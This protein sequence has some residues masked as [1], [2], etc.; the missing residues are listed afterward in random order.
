MS[1][2]SEIFDTLV[3]RTSTIL[4][5]YRH[6]S[7]GLEI[8]KNTNTALVKG[9]SV[10]IGEAGSGPEQYGCAVQLFQRDYTITITNAYT[11]RNNATTRDDAEKAIMEDLYLVTNSLLKTPS[12]GGISS[13]VQFVSD[14]G[15]EY[16]NTDAQEF[17]IAELTLN[18]WYEEAL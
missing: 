3:T 8:D 13:N 17:L 18:I 4:P 6:L 2:L 12:L 5:D 9:Y 14:S 7:D 1:K 16:L 15:S 10:V 11:M